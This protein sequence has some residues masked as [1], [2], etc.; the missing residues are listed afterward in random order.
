MQ[1]SEGAFEVTNLTGQQI[2]RTR[3]LISPGGQCTF[4]TP[5]VQPALK[6]DAPCKIQ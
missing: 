4:R 5:R 3:Y 6:G 1:P 2:A